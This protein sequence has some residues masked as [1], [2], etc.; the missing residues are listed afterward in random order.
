VR[1]VRCQNSLLPAD[2]DLP[3]R[4]A[5]LRYSLTGPTR[6]LLPT[7]VRP[8]AITVPFVLS[9]GAAEMPSPKLG[10]WSQGL[11]VQ[12][13]HKPARRRSSPAATRPRLDH[14]HAVPGGD[15]VECDGPAADTWSIAT[16]NGY[17]QI[18][19]MAVIRPAT[20]DALDR[21]GAAM[22]DR[23]GVRQAGARSAGTGRPLERM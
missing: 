14:L 21:L 17:R 7:L 1:A 5:V 23:A 16:Q 10:T 3:A 9:H 22:A 11:T 13:S 4:W 8:V 20:R 15:P 6:F 18:S 12:G 2:L 19:Y